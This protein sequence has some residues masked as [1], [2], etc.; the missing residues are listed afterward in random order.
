MDWH[1]NTRE[2][3]SRFNQRMMKFCLESQLNASLVCKTVKGLYEN[4]WF[5]GKTVYFNTQIHEY[6]ILFTDG[7]CLA[8]A[9]CSFIAH[10]CIKFQLIWSISHPRSYFGSLHPVLSLFINC[11][12]FLGNLSLSILKKCVHI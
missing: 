12:Y 8:C 3:S 10:L 11:C 1:L 7:I 4:G 2:S 9:L 5:K 6:Y